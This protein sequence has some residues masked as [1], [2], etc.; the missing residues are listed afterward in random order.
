MCVANG[1]QER[2]GRQRSRAACF[3]ILSIDHSISSSSSSTTTLSIWFV[4]EICLVG[5]ARGRRGPKGRFKRARASAEAEAAR[6]R[7][8]AGVAADGFFIATVV[9]FCVSSHSQAQRAA[10]FNHVRPT[11]LFVHTASFYFFSL[12]LRRFARAHTTRHSRSTTTASHGHEHQQQLLPIMST[13]T[14]NNHL[15]PASEAHSSHGHP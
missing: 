13:S 9:F 3:S 2:K 15:P 5:E 12:S 14:S 7:Q 1:E 8:A 4:Q 10:I 6:G 11:Q